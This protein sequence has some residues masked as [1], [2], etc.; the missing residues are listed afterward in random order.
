MQNCIVFILAEFSQEDI[1]R[2]WLAGHSL[3]TAKM[4]FMTACVNNCQNIYLVGGLF[5]HALYRDLLFAAFVETL[6]F[7]FKLV[8][9]TI[10]LTK[11]A[12]I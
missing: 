7:N 1:A 12:V 5:N 4:L 11:A 6:N 3:T 9:R 2:A 8:S 10:Y